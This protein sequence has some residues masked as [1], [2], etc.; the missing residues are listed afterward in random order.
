M[1]STPV[2]SFSVYHRKYANM[3]A[4][5]I[6]EGG[7]IPSLLH[8][9]ADT[10]IRV[11]CHVMGGMR[12]MCLAGGE[13]VCTAVVT[14]GTIPVVL[15]ALTA[16]AAF[17]PGADLAPSS[18]AVELSHHTTLVSEALLFFI[19]LAETSEA[20]V[21]EMMSSV[22]STLFNIL[23]VEKVE[24]ELRVAQTPRVRYDAARLWHTL[25]EH[26]EALCQVARETAAVRDILVSIASADT[27][28]EHVL[29]SLHAAGTLCNMYLQPVIHTDGVTVAATPAEVDAALAVVLPCL[30]RVLNWNPIAALT[31]VCATLN[32]GRAAYAAV[33]ANA[34]EAATAQASLDALREERRRA[35]ARAKILSGKVIAEDDDDDDDEGDITAA[36][37]S[38]AG[39]SSGSSAAQEAVRYHEHLLDGARQSRHSFQQE[40]KDWF[41]HVHALMLALEIL[42]N[43]AGGADEVADASDEV[44]DEGSDTEVKGEVLPSP[45]TDAVFNAI[46]G[47][48]FAHALGAL[49]HSTFDALS[50]AMT[51]VTPESSE[52]ARFI[53]SLPLRFRKGIA[54]AL[55]GI[56]D[57]CSS[58]M[59]NVAGAVCSSAARSA[60]APPLAALWEGMLATVMTAGKLSITGS[61]SVA[62][63]AS[64]WLA[65]SQ[66]IHSEIAAEVLEQIDESLD[67]DGYDEG[68]ETA[69]AA[70]ATSSALP[71]VVSQGRIARAVASL[72]N[73][74]GFNYGDEQLSEHALS[75]IAV[76]NPVEATP[77]HMGAT[78][79]ASLVQG[80]DSSLVATARLL[81][82]PHLLLATNTLTN[83]LL[84]A[85]ASLP[86]SEEP[87][88]MIA[89]LALSGPLHAS[90]DAP[91][92]ALNLLHRHVGAAALNTEAQ[93]HAVRLLSA[94]AR[95]IALDRYAI[96][97][98]THGKVAAVL[99]QLMSKADH[100]TLCVAASDSLMD[101]YG[102]EVHDAAF[103]ANNILHVCQVTQQALQQHVKVAADALKTQGA[104]QDAAGA[105]DKA[106]VRHAREVAKNLARFIRYK[107]SQGIA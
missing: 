37:G 103:Q 54:L 21:E 14:T 4:N 56:A 87:F 36:T 81:S 69:D 104:F 64:L 41:T 25:S 38:G 10:D 19:L 93:A 107:R 11:R 92:P 32:M 82:V 101:I 49:E 75:A 6:V 90:T 86:T 28:T 73:P 31:G 47:A 58:A 91:S 43:I 88:S 70:V 35:K 48:G 61:G 76:S 96:D 22:C 65:P 5:K 24:G 94:F 40:R 57:R 16:S 1:R 72:H 84:A 105:L 15:D 52:E 62:S 29:T 13:S 44:E 100:L 12:N 78:E 50:E 95:P 60:S 77:E 68:D 3:Q 45:C 80:D 74:L 7:G 67:S 53:A 30:S 8:R 23:K 20:A 18:A 97:D 71:Q 27:N 79:L 85:S 34:A 39:A 46:T 55:C 106:D 26:N 33:G 59:S 99:C 17:V 89:A 51:S 42:A 63:P 98:E 66:Y 9:L 102:D 83:A 2:S